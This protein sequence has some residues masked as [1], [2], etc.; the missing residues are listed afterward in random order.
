MSSK[1]SRIFQLIICIF[2]AAMVFLA[3]VLNAYSFK[4]SSLDAVGENKAV[5]LSQINDS[6][7]YGLKYGKQLGN[8]YG[9]EDILEKVRTSCDSDYVYIADA[10]GNLLYGEDPGDYLKKGLEGNEA[11]DEDG[12]SDENKKI[13]NES[14]M[15]H[16][17]LPIYQGEEQAGYIGT[18][19]ST[20]RMQAFS[21]PYV[22]NM[23]LYA[24]IEALCGILLFL[25]LFHVIKHGFAEKK[26][27]LLIMATIIAVSLL[28]VLPSYHILDVSYRALSED[29]AAD[30]LKQSAG[31]MERLL[32]MGV[33]Y[34]DI[35]DAN[36]YYKEIAGECM[37]VS[38][39]RLS[40]GK[41]TSGSFLDLPADQNNSVMHLEADIDETY[42]RGRVLKATINT[43][44]TTVT[45]IMI[46]VEILM[47]LLGLFV[48]KE[49]NRRKKVD[50]KEALTIEEF[51]LVR[52]LS[53]F[54]ASFRFMSV[55]FMSIVLVQIYTPVYV[56]GHMIPYEILIS[57]PMAGQVFVAMITSY[58][59]GLVIHRIGWKRT[60]LMGVVLM[61]MGTLASSFARVPIPFILAQMLVGTGLGFAKMGIDIYA[62]AVSSEDDMSKYTS[63]SNA[64]IIVGFSCSAALGA[65]IASIFG[66]SGA[67][68]VMTA[69]G[70][71]VFLLILFFGMDVASREEEEEG[72]DTEVEEVKGADLRFPVYLLTVIIPYFFIMMF[73]D[74]FFPVY[75]NSI[76][77]TTDVIGYVM[78]IYGIV[79][80]YVGT[81]LCPVLTEKMRTKVLMPVILLIL[82]L[83][84]FIFSVRNNIVA[85][86]VIVALIGLADGIMPSVQFKYV[87]ELPFAKK[88]GFSRALGI[89]GFFS[90]LIGAA[91]PV[92]FGVVMMFGNGGLALV[93]ALIASC[94]LVFIL[95]NRSFSA[96]DIKKG[97]GIASVLVLCLLT[98]L[99]P[100]RQ[101]RADDTDKLRIGYCQAGS[102][103]EFDY[104]IYQIGRALAERGEISAPGLDELEQGAD[105]YLVWQALCSA[106]SP[107][108]EFD[109]MGFM[110][111]TSGDVDVAKTIRERKID[112]VIT[113]GTGAG[114]EIRDKSDVDYM[115]FIA[116]DPVSSGITRSEESSGSSRAW[117]H[118]DVGVEK[119]A[120]SVM[121]DIFSP[122]KIGIVYN[123]QDPE[124][125]IYSGA[126]S[127]DEFAKAGK[128]EVVRAF[129]VDEFEDTKEAY[130]KYK[131]EMLSAHEKLALSGIDTF[132][133]TTSYLELEDME[134][135]LEPFVSR[136]IPV[137]SINSTE[138]VRCGALAAVEM[139]DYLNLG[140][141]AADTLAA[142]RD[143]ADLK[144]LPQLYSTAPFL[145]L[146][147]DTCRRTGLKLPLDTL[148]SASKIYGKYEGE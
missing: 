147:I 50:N 75:A 90:N 101:V 79:T 62:V 112:L 137:F 7:E 69:L 123:D 82:A 83:G 26:L 47:F 138:D 11:E 35:K 114:C 9:I 55:A 76:G 23:Y 58:L 121:D 117:A 56:W 124:A 51:G 71:G 144:D 111:I 87:Y 33:C 59:S 127:L 66:Y 68:L 31:D 57:L 103:Y 120:L 86:A 140:R 133:L 77:I 105:A 15:V 130:E 136:G 81:P 107:Y 16:I 100:Y 131:A 45:A 52:G 38:D 88:I 49:R 104:E 91:A 12:E 141:F 106:E 80:A 30:L 21:K 116:S 24:L 44:I 139:I 125:Y 18:G 61:M 13:W 25:I 115:N 17:L 8:Y 14:D 39:V 74:Y 85:A 109:S 89:E 118:V 46:A 6:I 27:R 113:M 4:N 54:F 28:S 29:V 70:G 110:D 41:G 132:V 1:K 145:V 22:Q 93:A 96:K 78:L 63:G 146:N 3:A 142:Y 95:I 129:V 32:E 2:I 43:L 99:L 72:P 34:S 94:A 134:E 5:I 126:A 119:R 42:I 84:L 135:V 67:Y 143:G 148:I 108:Y 73:V 36:D 102:Y 19:C 97:G 10:E 40:E 60:T 64:G 122:K 98:S 37:Q 20:E 128:R 48:G 65:L 92:I 53:F